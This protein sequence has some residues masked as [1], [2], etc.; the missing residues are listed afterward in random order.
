L[1]LK[2]ET[3]QEQISGLITALPRI[4]DFY[5]NKGYSFVKV[6]ELVV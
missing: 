5:K 2:D 4:K 1:G 3:D 6:S